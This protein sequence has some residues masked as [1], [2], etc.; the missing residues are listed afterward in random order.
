[1][2]D[3]T[4]EGTQYKKEEM[5]DEE[6]ALVGKLAQ[7]QQNKNSHYSQIADL[8]ILETAYLQKLKDSLK[9]NKEGK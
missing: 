3:I 1:M 6:I 4:I 7:I 5:N 9:K 2:S 8:D